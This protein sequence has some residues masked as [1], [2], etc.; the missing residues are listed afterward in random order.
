MYSLLQNVKNI[1][2]WAYKYLSKADEE[3]QCDTKTRYKWEVILNKEIPDNSWRDM[4]YTVK[5]LTLST[6][7]RSFQFRLTNRILVT[8]VQLQLWKIKSSNTCTFCN[9]Y[10][11]D[12]VH[13]FVN[14]QKVRSILWYPLSKWLSYFCNIDLDIDEYKII[15][16]QYKDSFPAMVNTIILITKHYIYVKR[17]LQDRLHF[18]ELIQTI[19]DY[20]NLE[21]I[22][23]YRN[24]KSKKHKAKWLMYDCV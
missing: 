2:G 20:K 7:L 1:S 16:N 13:L 11:E 21:S 14:C 3:K 22:I 15:F 6:K 19:S 24:Q 17:C 18:V 23:A 10:S 8:N 4:Y 5:K 9:K 12:Y